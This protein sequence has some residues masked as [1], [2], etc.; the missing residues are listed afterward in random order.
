[1]KRVQ[2]AKI[3]RELWAQGAGGDFLEWRC[4]LEAILNE[5]PTVRG[6]AGL[7][8]DSERAVRQRSLALWIL[9]R[10]RAR[11]A[12]KAI[13]NVLLSGDPVLSPYAGMALGEIRDE[14]LVP[15]VASAI[16]SPIVEVRDA[17]IWVA[18]KHIDFRALPALLHAA[19]TESN[20]T[21]R[22]WIIHALIG[23]R[24]ERAI[25][26]IAKALDDELPF[27]RSMAI[28]ATCC[29]SSDP[30]ARTFLAPLKRLQA[31]EDRLREHG[32][33]RKQDSVRIAEVLNRLEG[34][35]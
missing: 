4:F 8:T 31:D 13:L 6:L 7:A 14:R 18:T 32:K 19:E 25:N 10:I 28:W 17:A 35:Q 9:G 3:R 20:P 26:A 24:D 30:H 16:G 27:V 11:S 15:L 2:P 12:S 23:Y 1:M 22:M 34:R 29:V 33:E 21:I 5:F